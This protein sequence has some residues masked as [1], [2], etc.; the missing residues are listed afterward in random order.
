M[1]INKSQSIRSQHF[2]MD[3]PFPRDV[4]PKITNIL[5]PLPGLVDLGQGI[6]ASTEFFANGISEAANVFTVEKLS[7]LLDTVRFWFTKEIKNT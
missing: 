5:E 4:M 6:N 2:T 3:R 1:N 7:K